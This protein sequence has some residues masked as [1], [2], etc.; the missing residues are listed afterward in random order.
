MCDTAI[1][2]YWEQ[3]SGGS[4]GLFGLVFALY[5]LGTGVAAPVFGIWSSKVSISIHIHLY[6]H[7]RWR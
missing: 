5:G 7:T 6:L 3:I 1:Y 2:F 4:S